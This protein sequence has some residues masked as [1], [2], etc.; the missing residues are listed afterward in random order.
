MSNKLFGIEEIRHAAASFSRNNETFNQRFTAEE[1]II[2]WRA[3]NQSGWDFYPE[4]WE[5]RQVQEAL[6]GVPPRWDDNEQPVYEV[7]V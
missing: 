4:Q 6:K 2:I 1:L 3:W 7:N 5:E